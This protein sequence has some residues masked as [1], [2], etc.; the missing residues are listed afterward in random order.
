VLTELST[1]Q[2]KKNPVVDPAELDQVSEGLGGEQ[3]DEF[4]KG[5]G[6]KKGLKI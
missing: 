3:M 4:A 1:D 2:L 5:G 6:F